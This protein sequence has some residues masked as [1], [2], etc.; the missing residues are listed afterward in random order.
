MSFSDRRM[1]SATPGPT[2]PVAKILFVIDAQKGT[3]ARFEEKK[4]THYMDAG[5]PITFT[6]DFLIAQRWSPAE[7]FKV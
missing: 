7:D 3:L 1:S 4:M 6:W 5:K 2:G